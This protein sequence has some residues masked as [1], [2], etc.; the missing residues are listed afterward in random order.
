VKGCGD[1]EFGVVF[2][3][4]IDLLNFSQYS[5]ENSDRIK[6]GRL[7]VQVHMVERLFSVQVL[8]ERLV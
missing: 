1:R 2:A 7:E 4:C 5:P 8:F 6:T 3:A